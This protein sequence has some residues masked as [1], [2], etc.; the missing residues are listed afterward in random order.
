MN[1]PPPA[2]SEGLDSPLDC[3][4]FALKKERERESSWF[5]KKQLSIKIQRVLEDT[6]K[7]NKPSLFMFIHFLCLWPLRLAI[8]LNFNVSKEAYCIA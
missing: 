6:K 8:M 3:Y 5:S 1:A 2:L 7:M 4:Q